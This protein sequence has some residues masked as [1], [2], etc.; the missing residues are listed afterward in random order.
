MERLTGM[1][2]AFVHM[3]TPDVH[4]HV[5]GLVILDPSTMPGGYSFE[6]VRDTLA[7]RLHLVP[8]FRRRLVEVPFKLGQPVWIEDPDVD[9]DAHIHRIAVPAP[10]TDHQLAAIVG[11]IASVPLDRSRPLWDMWVIEGLEEGH[12]A[13]VTKVHHSTISGVTG[14]ELMVHLFD[15]TPESAGP[16]P[17]RQR[18]PEHKPSEIRLVA[19]AVGEMALRPWRIGRLLVKAGRGALNVLDVQR[20]P[21]P[22][23][24]PPT[25]PF[26]APRTPFNRSITSHRA[27]AYTRVRLDDVKLAKSTF[28]STVNDVVLAACTM[29]LRTWLTAH[30]ALPDRAL[31]ATLPVSIA[32]EPGEQQPGVNKVS[33]MMVSL[34]VLEPDPVAQLLAVRAATTSA[35]RIHQALG[36]DM[37]TGFTAAAPPW[38]LALFSRLYSRLDLA[39][40]H[41]P[42]H[43]LV[44]S[45]VPGPAFPLYCAGA[46][47][48]ATYPMG[49][50]LEGAGLNITVLSYRG[51]I[52][53]C[54]IADREM[55]PDLWDIA[56]GFGDAVTVLTKAARRAVRRR[57]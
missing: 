13:L 45:N 32:S 25:L 54:V 15:L 50:I 9:I 38:L 12:A 39:D 2:A 42:V 55:V 17:P 48:L 20:H 16:E 57:T 1:D 18:R 14:A 6:T 19:D 7:G 35:K 4:L 49:P 21:E 30:H 43:N 44:I 24:P 27:V 10:H 26:T 8:A 29:S 40:H 36:S 3:E 46:K 31:V 22:D 5:T 41:R 11:D 56:D 47:V 28:G 53:F 51:D 23:A 34:P 52:D 37:L 33:A